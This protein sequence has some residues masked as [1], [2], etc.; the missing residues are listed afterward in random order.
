MTAK[1]GETGDSSIQNNPRIPRCKTTAHIERLSFQWEVQGFMAFRKCA[2]IRGK[3]LLEHLNKQNILLFYLFIHSIHL[4]WLLTYI[5]RFVCSSTHAALPNKDRMVSSDFGNDTTGYWHLCMFPNGIGESQ[6]H[7]S[8]YLYYDKRDKR[9]AEF[10]FTVVDDN[11]VEIADS[12]LSEDF[13]AFS[14]GK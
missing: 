7:I 9:L 5:Y 8:L 12:K 14:S 6:G 1:L 10:S 4:Y 11:G 13:S 3:N 2:R